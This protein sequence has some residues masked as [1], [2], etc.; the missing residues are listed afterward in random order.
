MFFQPIKMAFAIVGIQQ[1]PSWQ[2][3]ASTY[4]SAI[5][6]LEFMQIFD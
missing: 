6:W 1:T 5:V 3:E 2:K 4:F